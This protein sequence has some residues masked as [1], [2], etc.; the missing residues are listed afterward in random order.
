[1]DF[2]LDKTIYRYPE[3]DYQSFQ[4]GFTGVETRP[5][6]LINSVFDDINLIDSSILVICKN[7]TITI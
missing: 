3:A 2:S 1:M 4:P 7:P 6:L 5:F